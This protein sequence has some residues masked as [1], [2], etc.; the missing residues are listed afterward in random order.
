MA[1]FKNDI[2]P[3]DLIAWENFLSSD[4]NSVLNRYG[5]SEQ[6]CL[7]PEWDCFEF[8]SI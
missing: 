5:E 6:P 7:V 3:T 4:T 8:L 2:N 1:I